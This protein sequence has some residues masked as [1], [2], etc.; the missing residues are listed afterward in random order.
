MPLNFEPVSLDKQ[1]NYLRYFSQ[2]P[3]KASDYSFVNLWGW[4]DVYGLHWAWSDQLVWIKQTIPNEVFWAPMGLWSEIDWNTCFDRYF[5][6]PT[7]FMRV[8]E[9]LMM[10]WRERIGNRIIV[11]ESR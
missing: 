6:P 7:V 1:N 9:D 2:C 10:L 3:Q 5:K 4:A 8:P 11:E